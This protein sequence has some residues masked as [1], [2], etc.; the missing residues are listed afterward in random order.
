MTCGIDPDYYSIGDLNE[1]IEKY[2]SLVYGRND[3]TGRERETVLEKDHVKF[4]QIMKDPR[5]IK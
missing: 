1:V 2:G 4:Y 3:I 5:A